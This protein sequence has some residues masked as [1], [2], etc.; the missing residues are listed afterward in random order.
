[1]EPE[2]LQPM[3]FRQ[4]ALAILLALPVLP[5]QS[6]LPE[7]RTEATAGGSIF[8]IRN[9]A[10]QPLTAYFIELVN[11]PGSFYQ[12]WQDETNSAP[13]PPGGEKHIPNTNMTVGA[14]PEYVKLQAAMFADGSTAGAPDK[15]EQLLAHRRYLLGTV[16]KLIASLEAN[17]SEPGR[18]VKMML[19][20]LEPPIDRTP[21]AM[22]AYRKSQQFINDTADKSLYLD[23]A[24]K[25]KSTPLKD[26][27]ATL[28]AA[29]S[30]LS[31]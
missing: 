19:E 23:I 31:H 2:E 6:P 1:M 15:V 12:L 4:S 8:H 22:R 9:A 5:A 27:L 16:R 18:Q 14:V 29:E 3:S 26:V 30:A 28:R 17:P 21:S 7:L 10:G 11:Y 20:L 25:L 24:A 13:I